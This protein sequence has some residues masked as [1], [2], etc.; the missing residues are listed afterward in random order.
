MARTGAA[1]SLQR[2]EQAFFD[3]LRQKDFIFLWEIVRGIGKKYYLCTVNNKTQGDMSSRREK[4]KSQK[5]QTRSAQGDAS[6]AKNKQLEAANT[7]ETKLQQKGGGKSRKEKLSNYLIDISKY[8]MTGVVIASMFKD[9]DDNRELIY[10]GG[11]FIAF[12]ALGVG[13]VLTDKKK[14]N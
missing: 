3:R 10:V 14:G 9:L 4:S 8:V 11:L 1:L 13:L 7:E 2:Q 6:L 12:T 5:P